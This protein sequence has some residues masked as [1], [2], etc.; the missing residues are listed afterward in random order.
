MNDDERR[1]WVLN[2]EGLYQWQQSSGLSV[3]EFIKKYRAEL[4]KIIENV[5]SGKKQAHYLAYESQAT[6]P[7]DDDDFDLTFEMQ[8]E[9]YVIGEGRRGYVVGYGNRVLGEFETYNKALRAIAEKM[10]QEKYWPNVFYVNDHGNVDLLSFSA[11]WIKG[12]LV[13]VNTKIV[14]SWV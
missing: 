11:K 6:N 3:R 10:E 4:D 2:D 8:D 5:T 13:K 9:A 12:K 14:R 1:L 7:D